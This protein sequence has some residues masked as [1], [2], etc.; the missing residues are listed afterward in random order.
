MFSNLYHA[1]Q[2]IQAWIKYPPRQAALT[3]KIVDRIRNSLELQVVVQTA[4]DEIAALL[5]LDCCSF[6]WYWEERGQVEI[7]C[8]RRQHEHQPSYLGEYPLECFGTMARAIAEGKRI[9]N[10]GTA[11]LTPTGLR[12]RIQQLLQKSSANPPSLIPNPSP[13]DYKAS[14]LIPV[15]GKENGIG[16]IACLCEQP[17]FWATPEIQ[18]LESIAESL[19]IGIRQAQ[20]YEQTQNQ[21]I[22]EQLVNHITSQTRQSF[23]PQTILTEA[24]SHLRSA[25]EVDRCLVH[26]VEDYQTSDLPVVNSET[27]AT[28]NGESLNRDHLYEVYRQPFTPCKDTFN[29][30]GPI[31]QW[32]IQHRRAVV[33]PDVTQDERIDTNNEEYQSA[34]IKSSLV[35]PVQAHGK[36]Y[37]ILFLNQCAYIR[38]WSK[39]DQEL[40][41]AVADQLAIS[42]QQA[43]LYTRTQ[44]QAAHN[45][46]QAQKLAEMIEELRLTQVQLIQSEK[47]SS[48]GRM[49]AGVAHE[50]NNPISFI[51]GNIPYLENYVNDLLRLVQAYQTEYPNPSPRLENILEEVEI[52]FLSKDLPKILQSMQSGTRRIQ[53]IVQLLQRFSRHNE[54]SLKLIDINVALENTLLIL[55]NQC[56]NTITIERHYDNLPHVEC[57]PKPINQV[58]LNLLTNAI[59]ALN[60]SPNSDKMITLRTQWKPS[61]HSSDEDR[62]EISIADNGVGIN[63]E[64]LSS[65]FEPFFTT[66]AVGEGRGLGLTVTYQTI[67]NQHQGQLDVRSQ[68]GQ[69]TEFILQIPVRHHHALKSSPSSSQSPT[70]ASDLSREVAKPS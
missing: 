15:T 64:V 69:G 58:F 37:A 53:E 28:C 63:P 54:A 24:I 38:Y 45:A 55:H 27:A 12:W 4:V 35:V 70:P 66:K 52:E 30:Q 22:R 17:R 10:R 61:I 46:M 16:F 26:L 49:V 19:E 62:V 8:E 18:F 9:V 1:F 6:F 43:Y 5:R 44:Q 57:Y 29:P 59:E 11:H 32:I 2:S 21:A 36:L 65:I 47:M 13:W 42:L 14:L 25:L 33:I 60:R 23:D 48:L 31:T 50:I 39:H 51:Y 67:V 41:Q 20:L 56:I 34:H 40:A 3:Q 7:V 68:P